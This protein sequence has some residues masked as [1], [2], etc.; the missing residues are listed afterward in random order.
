MASL[1]YGYISDPVVKVEEKD[2]E[3]WRGGGGG[4]GLMF[5]P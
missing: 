3:E 1:I 2:I 5:K 4:G